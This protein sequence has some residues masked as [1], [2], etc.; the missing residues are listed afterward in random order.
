MVPEKDD[1]TKDV[2]EI[3]GQSM[4]VAGVV[5]VEEPAKQTAKTTVSLR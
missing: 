5:A 3:E 2:L 4:Q 1:Y